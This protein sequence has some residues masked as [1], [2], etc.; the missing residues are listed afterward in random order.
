MTDQD[1]LNEIQYQLLETPNSGVSWG[2][3]CWTAA[4]VI[5]YCNQRQHRFLKETG[6]LYSQLPIQVGAGVSEVDLPD[7]WI[8]TLRA[9][10]RNFTTGQITEV[11]RSS[12]WE[13]DH[14]IPAWPSQTAARPQLYM[15]T[16]GSQNLKGHLAPPPTA[17]GE[18]SLI[19]VAL[20]GLLDGTGEIW[21]V[22][23][24]FVPYVKYGV[25]ADMLN[26][27]GRAHDPQRAGYCEARYNEGVE[28][29]KLMLNGWA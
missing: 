15:D 25:M 29:A 5:Q 26:K 11:P 1:T 10:W 18:L 9:S 24:D 8:A 22:P 19:C 20:A 4:E 2:S 16:E 7:V 13:A 6:I 14:S 27:V 28:A 12:W 3:G 17:A 21:T 23:Y